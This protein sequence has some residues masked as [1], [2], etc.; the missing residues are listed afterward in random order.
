[1]IE[2]QLVAADL[3]NA[4]LSGARINGLA[5]IDCR[6][7][8][9]KIGVAVLE[10][11]VFAFSHDGHSIILINPERSRRLRMEYRHLLG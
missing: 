8:G 9:L 11:M 5:L 4:D 1:M 6:V 3:T 2:N 10:N 7:K